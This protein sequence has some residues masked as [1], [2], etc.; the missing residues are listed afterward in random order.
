MLQALCSE[1]VQARNPTANQ[2][3]IAAAAQMV[4]ELHRERGIGKINAI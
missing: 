1:P 2:D 3:S 4:G